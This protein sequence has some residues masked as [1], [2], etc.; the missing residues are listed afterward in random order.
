MQKSHSHPVDS[1]IEQNFISDDHQYE[2]ENT[3]ENGNGYLH[4]A[5][6]DEH[7]HYEVDEKTNSGF[8]V[9]AQEYIDTEVTTVNF[10]IE[11]AGKR[12]KTDS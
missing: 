3:P 2:H 7:E 9:D 5:Y 8:D 1:G 12:R 10:D 4:E 6:H 11:K